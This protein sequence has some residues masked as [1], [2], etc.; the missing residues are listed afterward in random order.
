MC[1]LYTAGNM[2]ARNKAV[3]VRALVYTHSHTLLYFQL[4]FVIVQRDTGH[5]FADIFLN[6][7]H[8]INVHVT[9]NLYDKCLSRP[10]SKI[11]AAMLPYLWYL[12]SV[13]QE[14]LY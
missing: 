1:I 2:F 7:S 8:N 6:K 4:A 14:T 13:K 5:N 10:I 11:A 12:F 3:T 9:S